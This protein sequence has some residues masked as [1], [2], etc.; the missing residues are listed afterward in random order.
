VS[1]SIKGHNADHATIERNASR[2]L[3]WGRVDLRAG[4]NSVDVMFCGHHERRPCVQSFFHSPDIRQE[5]S[6]APSR[7]QIY[8]LT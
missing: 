6:A 8:A 3:G 2:T 4:G 5:I 1:H 7:I